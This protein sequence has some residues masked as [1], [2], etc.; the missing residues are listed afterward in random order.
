MS[1]APVSKHPR[2]LD[3]YHAG[4]V[5]AS[6]IDDYIDDW[7]DDPDAHVQLHVY[8]G[9]TWRE[10]TYWRQTALLPTE[11]EHLSVPNPD[12]VFVGPAHARLL[13]Q[14]HGPIRCR[15][16]CPVHWPSDH[17]LV[18]APLWWVGDIGVMMRLCPHNTLHPDPDDQQIR[19]H[20]ELARHDC[21]GCC[22]PTIDGETVEQ[23]TSAALLQHLRGQILTGRERQA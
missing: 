15:P 10:Y 13:L 20:P 6:A 22:A 4:L 5:P 18:D 17:P 7:R 23:R 1:A 8:L 3:L 11:R 2:F 16:T 12:H 9:M 21:D 14:V 19:L